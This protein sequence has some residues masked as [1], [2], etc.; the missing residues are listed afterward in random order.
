M[1]EHLSNHK[2][3]FSNKEVIGK[4]KELFLDLTKGKTPAAQPGVV[5]MGGLPGAGKSQ[6]TKRLENSKQFGGNI[7]K[8]DLDDY[9]EHHPQIDEIRAND[10]LPGVRNPER[11]YYSEQTGDFAWRVSEELTAMLR[12]A[13]YNVIIDGTLRDPESTIKKADAFKAMGYS[14]SLVEVVATDK[15]VAWQGTVDRYNDMLQKEKEALALGLEPEEYP[16]SV[17]RGYFETVIG[18]LPKSVSELHKSGKFDRI[19]LVDRAAKEHYNSLKTPDLDP[20]EKAYELI[21]KDKGRV[22]EGGGRTSMKGLLKKAHEQG[23]KASIKPRTPDMSKQ[24]VQ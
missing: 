15:E 3:A 5:F 1:F 6:A 12:E 21:A 11:S 9:R 10:R 8:V 24:P 20:Y 13:K 2:G 18:D 7:I 17:S 14:T 4:A 16:R 19:R 22:Q 23:E